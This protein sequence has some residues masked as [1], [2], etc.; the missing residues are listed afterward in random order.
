MKQESDCIFPD[1]PLPDP[2][3]LYVTSED[4]R[5]R[6]S[7]RKLLQAGRLEV[8]DAYPEVLR[9]T[10]T[11]GQ[12]ARM[13]AELLAFFRPNELELIRCRLTQADTVPSLAQLMHT[14]TLGGLMAWVDG[15]WLDNLLASGRLVTY[16]QPIVPNQRP[17]EVFA[18][19]CLLRGKEEDGRVILPDRLFAAARAT[20][21]LYAL[22]QVARLVAVESASKRQLSTCVF[23][24]FNPRFI[25]NPSR[26]LRGT[27]QATQQ[28]GI[29][30]ER[31]VFEVVESDE[32]VDFDRLQRV[33]DYCRQAGFRVALDDLGAGYSSLY[34]MALVKPDFVKLDMKLIRDV[35]KD[36][37]K[38]CVAGKLIEL[39]RQ[40]GVATIVEGVETYGEWIWATKH[41]AD[42]SQGFLFAYP[43]AV[44]PLPRD[45]SQPG[46]VPREGSVAAQD[47]MCVVTASNV[48]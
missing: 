8:T 48:V 16:F 28:S 30:A 37:Y 29:P 18:Y 46:H 33:L 22:D 15:L 12:L 26:D 2:I 47:P 39:A 34:L 1:R 14:Q 44:P 27:I 13:S 10:C 36:M 9:V 3:T 24:N 43:D 6:D 32:I 23:I 35:H 21:M 42:Y 40:L 17:S 38:S 7:L 5:I 41:G 25:E 20:G 19:E 11:A 31:F 45:P 4:S